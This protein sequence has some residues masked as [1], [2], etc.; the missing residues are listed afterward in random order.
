MRDESLIKT[1]LEIA[2]P[3]KDGYS[4]IIYI[5]DLIKINPKFALGNGGSWCRSDGTLGNMFIIKKIK[6]K[7][8][9]IG[10]Q[11]MG[12]NE[13]PVNKKIPLELRKLIQCERCAVLGIK[14]NIEADHKSGR[15]DKDDLTINDLQ[16]LSKG[17][18]TAKRA[19]CKKC[20]ES[21]Q[22]FDA[23]ILGYSVSCIKGDLNSNFCEGCY[24]YD[25]KEF[26]KTISKNY[27]DN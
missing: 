25:I 21:G 18:N 1:F 24:W 8:K 14:S 10:I 12:I 4:D 6:D 19:H 26:N 27:K 15:Y 9:I 17:A 2:K 11:L 7:N 5:K 13:N 22:R 20:K 3:N 16:P 23:K